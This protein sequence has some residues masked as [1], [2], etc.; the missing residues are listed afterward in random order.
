MN[1]LS[2]DPFSQDFERFV[3]QVPLTREVDYTVEIKKVPFQKKLEKS[4]KSKKEEK[5]E[6]KNKK[7]PFTR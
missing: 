6:E 7:K 1:P 5:E 3:F 4:A 2:N